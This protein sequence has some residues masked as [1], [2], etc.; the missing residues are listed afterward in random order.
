MHNNCLV[1]T[2]CLSPEPHRGRINSWFGETTFQTG[3]SMPC[4]HLFQQMRCSLPLGCPACTEICI[5]RNDLRSLPTNFL[6]ST[7]L[8]Y[9]G[10]MAHGCLQKRHSAKKV[11]IHFRLGGQKVFKRGS[12]FALC[13][14]CFALDLA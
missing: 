13:S 12:L 2:D 1:S 8:N 3:D 4:L 11:G 10:A 7:R 6:F 9:P 5:V 14:A